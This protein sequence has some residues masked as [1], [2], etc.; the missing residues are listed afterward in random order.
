M[1]Y[2]VTFVVGLYSGLVTYIYAVYRK[3]RLVAG[4]GAFVEFVKCALWVA[5]WFI[6]P[7]YIADIY[8]PKEGNRIFLFILWILPTFIVLFIK[9][10]EAWRRGEWEH[11]LRKK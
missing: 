2:F 3:N 1:L 8:A 5:F 6:P 9:G 11:Q 4:T 7:M 10:R